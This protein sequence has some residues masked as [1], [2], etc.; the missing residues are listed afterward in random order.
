MQKMPGL[1]VWWTG[2]RFAV[3]PI[4]MFPLVFLGWF[5]N[6]GELKVWNLAKFCSELFVKRWLN[7]L[8]QDA[9]FKKSCNGFANN[10]NTSVQFLVGVLEENVRLLQWLV[11]FSQFNAID[12]IFCSFVQH[13]QIELRTSKTYSKRQSLVQNK[14]IDVQNLENIGCPP[15]V[16]FTRIFFGTMRLFWNFLDSN[17]GS[18]LR[19][20]RYFATQW[21]SK[22]PTGSPF[23]IFWHSD[24]VQKSHLN[25]FWGLANVPH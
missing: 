11:F 2:V 18:P 15:L 9:V 6:P 7:D 21:I 22:N 8:F 17:K 5:W 25:F 10:L 19:L 14:N 24:T 16:F 12:R 3:W 1:P 20:F 13:H 23:Y 4:S